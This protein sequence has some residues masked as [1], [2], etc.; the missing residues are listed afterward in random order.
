MDVIVQQGGI[1]DI[2]ADVIVVNLF[3]GVVEPGGATGEVDRAL[4]GHIVEVIETG[5]LRGKLG[6]TVVLYPRGAVPAKRVVVVGLG[7]AASFG[8]EDIREAAGAAARIARKLGAQD[9]ATIIHGGGIGGIDVTAAAQ[10]VVEGTLLALYRYDAAGRKTDTPEDDREIQTL[11]LVEFDSVKIPPIEA[12]AHAGQIIAEATV[13]ARTLVNRPANQMTPGRLAETAQQVARGYGLGCRVLGEK[14]IAA[15][16]MG[17]FL[18]VTQGAIE[19]AKFIVLEHKPAGVSE[20]PVVLVGKGV[21]FDTGGYTLKSQPSMAGMKGD[22]AGAAAVIA[23]MQAIARLELP[24]YVVGL[25]PAVENMISGN[26]YKLNDVFTAKNGVTIEILSTDAEG[27]LILADA[28]CYADKLNPVA[29]IDI[30]TLT[31][32]KAVAL[33]NRYS[34]LFANDATGNLRDRLLAAGQMAAEPLWPLP[35]DPAYDRQLKSRVADLKNTGGRYASSVTAARFLAH[36]TGD[37]PWAHLDI[38]KG[39]FY[40]DNPEDTPRSYLT[41]GATGIGVRTFVEL[42]RSWNDDS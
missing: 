31:G 13:F 23:T 37:W 19:P 15:E 12:G 9:I 29:V 39:E 22:M 42:L 17:V 26:A 30:A 36:F 40:G 18:A 20:Q 24:L 16:G 1:Q 28:L 10:A 41:K 4:N 8:L 21:T 33:G 6:E 38:A 3:E 32:G 5:D 7:D 34:A 25:I 27:R 2:S 14:A 35:L 11:R